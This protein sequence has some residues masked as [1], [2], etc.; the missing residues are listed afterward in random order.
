MLTKEQREEILAAY[1]ARH[2]GYSAGGFFEEVQTTGPSHPAYEWFEWDVRNGWREHNLFLA[3]Q[4]V[5]GLTVKIVPGHLG[6]DRSISVAVTAP[7]VLSPMSGRN[8]GGG[9]VLMS[10]EHLDELCRQGATA[11]GSWLTRYRSALEFAGGSPSGVARIIKT[12]ELASSRME[13]RKVAVNSSAAQE[14]AI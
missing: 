7:M 14:A 8:H 10:E 2:G 11:L 12:L 13:G 9:Y 3:R 4:F 1:V 5:I 6:E